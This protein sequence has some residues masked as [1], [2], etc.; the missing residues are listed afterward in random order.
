V[1]VGIGTVIADDPELT[2]RL[3]KGKNP[4]RIVVD[5][6]LRMPANAKIL[7]QHKG[8]VIIAT[9][10]KK[11][12][13]SEVRNQEK[14]I[15]ALN[16]SGADVLLLHSRNGKVDLKALMK[17]LGKREI[18]SLIIEGGG[19]LAASAIK[20]GIVDKITI[21]VAPKF[22]GKEGL[23]MIGEL[24]IRRLKDAICLSRLECRKLGDDLLLEGYLKP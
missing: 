4:V 8:S 3:V 10:K 22:F 6:R 17:E 14:K 12:Q 13:E 1:M 15:K 2:V 23:S 5:S 21:F 20:E 24:G 18:T 11:S 7:N 19:S 16:A 9:I